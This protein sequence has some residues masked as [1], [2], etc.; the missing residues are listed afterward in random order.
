MENKVNYGVYVLYDALSE[1]YGLPFIAPSKEVALRSCIAPFLSVDEHALSD[2]KL[3]EIGQYDIE[4]GEVDGYVTGSSVLVY[5][6]DDILKKII[7]TRESLETIKNQAWKEL[8]ELRKIKENMNK[9][10]EAN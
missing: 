2:F 6:S 1:A 8:C 5:D 3:Y 7:E 10:E 9:P 4:V